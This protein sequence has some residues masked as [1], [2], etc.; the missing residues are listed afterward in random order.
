MVNSWFSLHA[1]GNDMKINDLISNY[2]VENTDHGPRVPYKKEPVRQPDDKRENEVKARWE[3]RRK[4]QTSWERRR[5]NVEGT[6]Y[7][8]EFE[9]PGLTDEYGDPIYIEIKVSISGLYR[10]GDPGSYYDPPEPAAVE[11]IEMDWAEPTDPE[12]EGGPL[13]I[14]DLVALE[15]WF[16]T[17]ETQAR[18]EEILLDEVGGF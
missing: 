5:K 16:E 9:R 13:R 18:A 17:E 14:E 8:D 11:D 1:E 3:H 12:P 10:K 2:V 4:L 7:N 15:D 6:I